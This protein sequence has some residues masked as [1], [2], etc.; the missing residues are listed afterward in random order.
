MLSLGV[1]PS[2]AETYGLPTKQCIEFQHSEG[3]MREVMRA[4]SE[5]MRSHTSG[6]EGERSFTT[7]HRA[8]S[9]QLEEDIED[10]DE[11]EQL[12]YTG[13]PIQRANAC[14]PTEYIN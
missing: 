6:E 1:S 7:C 4:A 11:V 2:V 5:V 12:S 9:S 10:E 8:M 13:G 3:G 14:E